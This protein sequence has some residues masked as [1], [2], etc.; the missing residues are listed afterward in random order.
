MEHVLPAVTTSVAGVQTPAFV[1]RTCPPTA[2][3]TCGGVSPEFRLRPSLSARDDHRALV[4]RGACRRSS[5]S[6][7]R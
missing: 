5:D 3:W 2:T 6:G 7:L 4:V 1:E